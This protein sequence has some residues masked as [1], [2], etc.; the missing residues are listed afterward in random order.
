MGYHWLKKIDLH[1]VK[2]LKTSIVILT[3]NQ[4]A[5][6]IRCLDS[7]R[8]YT[9]EPYEII[10]VDNG[11]M[12]LTADYFAL[13]TD[14]QFVKNSSNVGFARGCNQGLALASGEQ[15]LFLNNDTVVTPQWLTNMLYVLYKDEDIGMVGPLTN[16]ASGHQQIAVPYDDLLDLDDFAIKH[17]RQH[18]GLETEVRRLIGFCML[19]KQSVLEEVGAFDERYGLGNFEDDDLCLRV[20]NAGYRLVIAN[21]SFIHHV[22]H[23]TT[24]QLEQAT[25]RQLLDTN[26]NEAR[27]KWQADIYELLYKPD[28]QLTVCIQITTSNIP[29]LACIGYIQNIADEI[30]VFDGNQKANSLSL[31]DSVQYY[32]TDIPTQQIDYWQLAIERATHPYVFFIHSD[33]HL[34]APSRRK[35]RALKRSLPADIEA[36]LNLEETEA[37]KGKDRYCTR[38]IRR[39][40]N[41]KHVY[42]Q[43]GTNNVMRT[44]IPFIDCLQIQSAPL[45]KQEHNMPSDV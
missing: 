39:G 44:Q 25:L 38:L 2:A 40:A 5:H 9:P 13:Q 32:T 28:I 19:V 17:C 29:V 24:N 6:T 36:V 21:D 20:A 4:L 35:I 34:S 8:K 26:R 23:V 33:E 16:Y 15:V 12:D 43:T 10:V 42:E 11:S 7:I 18:A 1:E 14:I 45:F 22:G 37:E 31:P 27:R 3:L 41:L 30:M